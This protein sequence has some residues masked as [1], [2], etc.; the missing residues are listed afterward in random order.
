MSLPHRLRRYL[1]A[2][3]GNPSLADEAMLDAFERIVA[4]REVITPLGAFRTA[5]RIAMRM[6]PMRDIS[7]E[8]MRQALAA[9]P[10]GT[11]AAFLLLRLEHFSAEEASEIMDI[12]V[13]RVIDEAR[14]AA[15][16]IQGMLVPAGGTALITDHDQLTAMDLENIAADVGFTAI[17]E[18]E[19]TVHTLLGQPAPILIIC[20]AVGRDRRDT[21][22]SIA[23]IAERFDAAVLC[24][25]A[26]SR[27]DA[28]LT[29]V[30]RAQLLRKPFES[31]TAAR[32]ILDVVAEHRTSRIA[33][34]LDGEG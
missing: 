24:V 29:R 33:V 28:F 27:A 34:R 12:T 22:G 30:P 14:R 20:E 17:R 5:H 1:R 2:H 16:D 6:T 18:P 8:P 9:L 15:R 31:A 25:T 3:L 10:S 32:T 26:S 13:E 21:A 23:A 19:P 7:D 11:R 4:R